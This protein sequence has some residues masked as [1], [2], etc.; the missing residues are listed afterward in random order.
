MGEVEV[1]RLAVLETRL[2]ALPRIEA[3]LDAFH[4]NYVTRTEVNE[5]VAD[6]RREVDQLREDV[7]S[8]R[9]SWPAW[10]AALVAVLAWLT[11]MLPHK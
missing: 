7:K 6:V 10:I 4:E 1:E 11:Q 8:G 2:E 5:K 3:K 9:K